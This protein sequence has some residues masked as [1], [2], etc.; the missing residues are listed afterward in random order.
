MLDILAEYWQGR[1]PLWKIF[2]LWG[3]VG[4]WTLAGLVLLAVL[5]FGVSWTLYLVTAVIMIA[6]TV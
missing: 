3:V 4:S 2:W 6:Y 1:G 5:G